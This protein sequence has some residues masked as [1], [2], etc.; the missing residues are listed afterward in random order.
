VS[1]PPSGPRPDSPGSSRPAAAARVRQGGFRSRGPLVA[2]S[3]TATLPAVAPLAAPAPANVAA[4]AV[5]RNPWIDALAWNPAR[6]LAF[7]AFLLLLFL[8]FSLLHEYIAYKFGDPYLILIATLISVGGTL[9]SGAL[10]R[11]SRSRIV[12]FWVLFGL[13]VLVA[14]PFSSWVGGSLRFAF[15]T[16]FRTVFILIFPAAA[17]SMDLKDLRKVFLAVGFGAMLSAIIARS[18]AAVAEG[19]RTELEFGTVRN[20]GDLAA[21]CTIG[22]PFMWFVWREVPNKL[23]R[24]AVLVLTASNV[25]LI[26]STAARSALIAF[27][28]GFVFVLIWGSGRMK[29]VMLLVAGL[30]AVTFAFLPRAVLARYS[31]L[32]SDQASPEAREAE[33]SSQAREAVARRALQYTLQRPLFGVGIDTFPDYDAGVT[34]TQGAR[35]AQWQET[36]NGYLQVGVDSGIPALTFYAA[37]LIGAWVTALRIYRRTRQRPEFRFVSTAAF[38]LTGALLM[39]L[40]FLAFLSQGYAFWA[41]VFVGLAVALKRCAE[42]DRSPAA[43]LVRP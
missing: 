5:P 7:G 43:A 27:L 4:R 11:L 1:S 31:T 34:K 25:Y 39:Y 12:Q 41:P 26:L 15:S 19:G 21:F 2:A 13:W 3:A 42:S 29:F 38:A 20:S 32:W 10:G 23:V 36:H 24:A 8:K 37:A 18:F 22:L 28:I 30:L 35:R 9:I 33:G 14:L 17:L 6:R 16:F 40:V